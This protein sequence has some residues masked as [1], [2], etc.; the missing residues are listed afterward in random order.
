MKILVVGGGGR[1]HAIVRALARSRALAGAVLHPRQRRDRRRRR[2]RSPP[3]T[4][5][6]VRG[7]TGDRRRPRRHRSRG[8]AR[9]RARRRARGRPGSPPSAR[10]PTR[11]GSRA[12]SSTR[13]RRC[14]GGRAD[15]R[16]RARGLDASRRSPISRRCA[17]PVVLK[18]DGLAAGKGVIIADRR[19][20]R[21]R[22]AVEAFFTEQRFGATQV[23]DR[24]VPRGRGALDAG[25]LRR[26]QRRPARP[27]PGL[28]ADLRRRPGP[29]HRRHGQLLAGPRDR[30]RR[31]RPDRRRGPRADRRG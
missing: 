7:R 13:R 25:P 26:H 28:Q 14:G 18:A 6:V 20:P 3:T 21:R 12:R 8:A 22:A 16:A 4:D 11:R 30:R 27:G 15:G 29:E 9:R 23:A 5:G 19:E 31:G 17:Y 2:D 1:E 24:G 10:A